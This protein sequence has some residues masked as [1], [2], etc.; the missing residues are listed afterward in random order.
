MSPPHHDHAEDQKR[1][2]GNAEQFPH[3]TNLAQLM[4]RAFVM[5]C[6]PKSGKK[7]EMAQASPLESYKGLLRD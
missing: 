7:R 4:V 5:S 3:G 6:R 2:S 1:K